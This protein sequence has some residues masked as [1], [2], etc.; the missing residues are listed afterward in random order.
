MYKIML[1][2]VAAGILAW[3]ASAGAADTPYRATATCPVD[4]RP[5]T[6]TATASYSTWGLELDA[7]PIGST[8]FPRTIPQ[9][10]DSLFPV[11]KDEFTP[12]EK[13]TLRAL[14][15]T[16]EYVAV[17]NES[18][19]YLLHF[20]FEKM[21]EGDPMGLAWL[22]MQSTW[23]VRETDPVRYIRYAAETIEA[24]D[25]ALPDIRES[26][27]DDWWYLQVATAN[28]Q[29]QAGEFE[30]ATRRLDA[31]TGE[32]PVGDLPARIA[33]TRQMIAA[34]DRSPGIM[35]DAR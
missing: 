17:Q 20:V 15:A 35:P 29:R 3:S 5:F 9:C 22:L 8:I 33:L 28:V 11:F 1:G 12:V 25:A 18:S 6:W 23:Q 13:A 19:Y 14:V 16:P 2:L 7:K 24:M 31:L 4:D 32:P 10:P 27:P 21:G 26:Q 30:G 34:Q